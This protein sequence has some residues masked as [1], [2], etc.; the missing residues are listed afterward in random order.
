MEKKKST[1][2]G[3]GGNV[4]SLE[5]KKHGRGS[6]FRLTAELTERLT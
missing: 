4:G 6:A 2:G 1:E 3:G 5:V